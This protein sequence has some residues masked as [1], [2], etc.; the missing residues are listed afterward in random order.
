MPVCST[1]PSASVDLVSNLER[2]RWGNGRDDF[3]FV[4]VEL[5]RG[6]RGAGRVRFGFA[7]EAGGE[8]GGEHVIEFDGQILN[9]ETR[10]YSL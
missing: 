10:F 9:S 7:V 4:G 3:G 6:V 8:G 1:Q 2:I 5:V